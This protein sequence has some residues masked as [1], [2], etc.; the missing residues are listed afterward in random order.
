MR[1]LPGQEQQTLNLLEPKVWLAK[2]KLGGLSI[3]RGQVLKIDAFLDQLARLGKPQTEEALNQALDLLDAVLGQVH[4]HIVEKGDVSKN[5]E[6]VSLLGS[7]ALKTYR[8]HSKTLADKLRNRA[9]KLKGGSKYELLN[10]V[11]PLDVESAK[12]G[13]ESWGL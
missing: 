1:G 3:R 9:E 12:L 8:T 11:N 5:R 4:S 10:L 7:Q 2:T 13:Q 6:A